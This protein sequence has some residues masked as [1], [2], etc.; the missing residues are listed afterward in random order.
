MQN[1]G[2]YALQLIAVYGVNTMAGCE[3]IWCKIKDLTTTYVNFEWLLYGDFNEIPFQKNE[4][5]MV[6]L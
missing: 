1:M 5:A 3:D 2:G 6:G 4:M